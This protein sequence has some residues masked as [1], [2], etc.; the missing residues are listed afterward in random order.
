MG[1][2][3]V[4]VKFPNSRRYKFKKNVTMTIKFSKNYTALYALLAM[5]TKQGAGFIA[6]SSLNFSK[7]MN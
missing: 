6:K 3:E 1:R 2:Q 7:L 4:F 5:R